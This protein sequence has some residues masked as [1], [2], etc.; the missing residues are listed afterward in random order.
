MF[1]IWRSSVP[2]RA[3]F[4]GAMAA[5]P[6]LSA[7]ATTPPARAGAP[8][9]R[10]VVDSV[11]RVP[12]LERTHWGIEVFDAERR[13]PLLRLNAESHFIP[14]SN[15]KLLVTATALSELGPEWRYRTPLL[16]SGSPGD[17]AV[18]ELVVVGR[19]D[20]TLSERFHPTDAAPLDS[21]ADSVAIAGIRRIALLAVDAAYFDRQLVH[22]TWEVGDLDWYY[23]APVAAFGVAEGAV[24]IL[25]AP[26]AAPGESAIVRLAGP[27]GRAVV[28]G[29]VLTDTAGAEREWSLERRPGTDTLVFSGRLPLDAAP[30]TVWVTPVDPALHAAVSFRDALLERGIEVGPVR[31]EYGTGVAVRFHPEV[32][33]VG[34]E[35]PRASMAEV[36]VPERSGYRALATWTSPPMRDIVAAVLKPSQ[37]WIAEHLL[38]TLGAE[39]GSGGSWAE[40]AEVERRFLFD[41]VG[42]DSMA[43]VIRDGSGLSAQNLLTPQ[44]VVQLLEHAR[45]Q[46]WGSLF[47]AALAEPGADGTLRRRLGVLSGRLQAKTGTITHVNSLSGYLTTDGGKEISFSILTNASGR[48][49]GEIRAAMDAI[50]EA[51]ARGVGR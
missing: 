46:P 27:A 17:S 22:P 40:G 31:V 24:P 16:A 51:M 23:A 34:E 26:G 8:S 2:R 14:A 10:E 18:E 36:I 30:D 21:L 33:R 25:R 6:L 48:P 43:V 32:P 11:V 47:R 35:P 41:E 12:P 1:E 4:M 13:R 37:N 3:R 38:K 28:S 19:G 29:S 5:V 49:A 20:P 15:Q 9:L 44:A 50:V 42:I 39:R 7:C 45:A